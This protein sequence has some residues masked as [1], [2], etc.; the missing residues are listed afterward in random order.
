MA[1]A[2][3]RL[4]LRV[5]DQ[6]S[7]TL[8]AQDNVGIAHGDLCRL[9]C[10]VVGSVDLGGSTVIAFLQPILIPVAIAVIIA[11]LLDPV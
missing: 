10:V 4:C 3:H 1:W 6:I 8:A 11:Y 9:A 7:D 2:R 5:N